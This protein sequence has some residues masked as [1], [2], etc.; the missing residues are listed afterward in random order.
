MH[1]RFQDDDRLEHGEVIAVFGVPFGIE[2]IREEFG[3]VHC[4]AEGALGE[5]FSFYADV[6]EA[7]AVKGAQVCGVCVEVVFYGGE[8][9]DYVVNDLVRYA[10]CEGRSFCCG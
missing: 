8:V 4:E 10:G 7:F 2:V 6:V 9:A 5:A 3:V 1:L